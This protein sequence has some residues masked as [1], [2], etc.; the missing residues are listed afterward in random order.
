MERFCLFHVFIILKYFIYKRFLIFI[1][2]GFGIACL[3]PGLYFRRFAILPPY[4]SKL[5]LYGELSRIISGHYTTITTVQNHKY[6]ILL[7]IYNNILIE[8]ICIYHNTLIRHCFTRLMVMAWYNTPVTLENLFYVLRYPPSPLSLIRF[9]ESSATN[10]SGHFSSRMH[11]LEIPV[12]PSPTRSS[13]NLSF[14][15]LILFLDVLLGN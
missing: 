14:R 1:R 11:T 9:F 2:R 7:C 8:P 12:P 13:W 3:P 15:F 4:V 6:V 10:I 5:V